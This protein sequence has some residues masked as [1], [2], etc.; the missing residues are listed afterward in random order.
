MWFL[1]NPRKIDARENL[2]FYSVVSV[3]SSPYCLWLTMAADYADYG[4]HSDVRDET[5]VVVRRLL[6]VMSFGVPLSWY[7]GLDIWYWT[8]NPVI[9]AGA[10]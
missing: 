3:V 8:V 4:A 2:I 5:V 7:T 6:A 9:L 1:K 10:F